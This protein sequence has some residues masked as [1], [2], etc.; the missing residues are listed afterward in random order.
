M[1]LRNTLG[2]LSL[3]LCINACSSNIST[4]GEELT[5]ENPLVRDTKSGQV[6]ARLFDSRESVSQNGYYDFKDGIEFSSS[7]L[8]CYYVNGWGFT[9]MQIGTETFQF[10]KYDQDDGRLKGC[11]GLMRALG[12]SL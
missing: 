11:Y 10:G 4:I 7:S 9:D 5:R 1:N 8:S 2:A 12:N 3:G 6:S